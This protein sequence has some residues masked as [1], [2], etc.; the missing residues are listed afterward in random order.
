[1]EADSNS[2]AW[3]W[4]ELRALSLLDYLRITLQISLRFHNLQNTIKTLGC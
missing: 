3:A 2:Q 1:M 4:G